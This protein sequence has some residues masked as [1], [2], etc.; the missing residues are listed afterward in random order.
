MELLFALPFRIEPVE[1]TSTAEVAELVEQTII[2]WVE[3]RYA[4]TE[5]PAPELVDTDTIEW[6]PEV[7]FKRQV[8]ELD[9]GEFLR[10]YSWT[11]LDSTAEYFWWTTQCA[12]VSTAE[13]LALQVRLGIDAEVRIHDDDLPDP[14]RPGF[15]PDLFEHPRIRCVRRGHVLTARAMTLAG[16]DIE[17]FCDN[18]LFA[19]ERSLSLAV[20]T[21]RETRRV[22]KVFDARMLA[23]R[24]AG[25]AKVFEVRDD[26]T[27]QVLNRFVG[28]ALALEPASIGWYSPGLG[29]G[30]RP[31]S[32]GKFRRER[33]EGYQEFR[34]DEDPFDPIPVRLLTDLEIGDR[35]FSAL[36]KESASEYAEPTVFGELRARHRAEQREKLK[37]LHESQRD[38]DALLAI[39]DQE[40]KEKSAELLE[41][42]SQNRELKRQLEAARRNIADLSERIGELERPEGEA[43][44]STQEEPRTV[45]AIVEAAAARYPGIEILP[46]ALDSAKGVPVNFK[47][48]E[49]VGAALK[50]LDEYAEAHRGGGGRIHGGVRKFFESRGLKYKLLSDTARSRYAEAYTFQ[51]ENGR[52]LFEEH[53][54]IGKKSRNTCL[55]IHFSTRLKAGTVVVAHVGEHLPNTLS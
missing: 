52:Q 14:R 43:E 5:E 36:V 53:F 46:S 19:A 42:E 47:F 26:L 29:V 15:L 45:R 28:R 3:R 40:T 12:L 37:R 7:P 21:P 16:R 24:L 9:S 50:A 23:N 20:V 25:A 41:L 1:G 30:A 35:E 54:T 4:C 33:R 6:D 10:S 31:G 44:D 49:R 8:C 22:S 27:R 38:A 55:S 13:L 39:A 18:E 34:F 17:R 11:L 48:P 32:T 51:Y 2:R